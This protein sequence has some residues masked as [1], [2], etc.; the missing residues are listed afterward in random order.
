M[1]NLADRFAKEVEL[2]I[3]RKS[4]NSRKRFMTS[5]EKDEYNSIMRSLNKASVKG[6]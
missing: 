5:D 4:G 3:K 6:F 2:S 1:A